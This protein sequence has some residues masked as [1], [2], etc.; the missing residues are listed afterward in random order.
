MP[1][2]E[3]TLSLFR[4]KSVWSTADISLTNVGRSRNVRQL[5]YVKNCDE[6]WSRRICSSLA[7]VIAWP[8]CGLLSGNLHT[9]CVIDIETA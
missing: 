9:L 1:K 4:W 6:I 3:E 7:Q 8:P 2:Y 5:L